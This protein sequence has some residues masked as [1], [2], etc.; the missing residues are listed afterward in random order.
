MREHDA[1]PT[2]LA[3]AWLLFAAGCDLNKNDALEQLSEA[4]LLSAD[5][6]VQFA[7]ASHASSQAVMA[8]SDESSVALAQ[9]SEA[10]TRALQK[11]V[12][13]LKPMLDALAYPPES[14]ALAGFI[15]RFA[16]YQKLDRQILELAVENTNLKA[17]RLAFGPAQEAANNFR[18]AL[19]AIALEPTSKYHWQVEALS[20][21]ALLTVREI[22]VLQAPHI[23]DADDAVMTGMEKQMATSEASARAALVSLSALL[24]PASQTKLVDATKALDAFL[25]LNAQIIVLSRRNTNVRSLA[26]SLEQRPPLAKACEDSLRTLHDL[27]A[28]R[29][30]LGTR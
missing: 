17:Q 21:T 29:G 3:A 26:L 27:L 9:E 6:Q 2:W 15:T 7:R 30:Y 1:R 5:M 16:D 22:Q 13:T 23:A 28:K 20:T 12:D 10:A 8:T 25:A 18:D 24:P 19:K 14:E 4:R 11:D